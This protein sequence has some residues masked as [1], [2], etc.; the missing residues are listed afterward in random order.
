[1]PLLW[2]QVSNIPTSFSLKVKKAIELP[3]SEQGKP[4]LFFLVK[5]VLSP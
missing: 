4:F 1:M 3:V 2:L 5:V